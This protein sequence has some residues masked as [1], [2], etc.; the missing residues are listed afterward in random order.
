M[1]NVKRSGYLVT[2]PIQ[3]NAI[4]II[5]QKHLKIAVVY[6]GTAVKHQ[7]D[8]IVLDFVDKS[9]ITFEDLRFVV[10]DEADR[11]L[12][13]GFLP[14]VEKIMTHET[15]RS[16]EERQSLMF[17]ATFPDWLANI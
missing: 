5:M 3:K 9:F 2:T 13:L 11:M 17:S 7:G 1:S 4:P 12:D 8:N 14:S 10:L 16:K 15:M 6:G